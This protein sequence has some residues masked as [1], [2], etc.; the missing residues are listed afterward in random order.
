MG[1]PITSVDSN[2][3]TFGGISPMDTRNTAD[4]DAI[5]LRLINPWEINGRNP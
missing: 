5:G 1:Q 2:D 3:S 4:F